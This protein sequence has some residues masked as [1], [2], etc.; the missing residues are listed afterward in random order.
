VIRSQFQPL[1]PSILA[2]DRN[3]GGGSEV[4]RP[5]VLF[6]DGEGVVFSKDLLDGAF[7]PKP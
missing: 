3:R 6:D 2:G 1:R 5:R 4:H 7:R